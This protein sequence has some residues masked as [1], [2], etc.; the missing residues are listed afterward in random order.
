MNPQA[1]AMTPKQYFK[2]RRKDLLEEYP[3]AEPWAINETLQEH[4]LMADWCVSVW[5]A[6][7]EGEVLRS[8]ILDRLFEYSSH[9]WWLLFKHY[10]GAFP[11]GYLNP[12]ARKKQKEQQA[13]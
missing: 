8:I 1:H 6:A 7:E 12:E 9:T 5:K 11:A 13:A 2:A 4:A 3:D 10:P